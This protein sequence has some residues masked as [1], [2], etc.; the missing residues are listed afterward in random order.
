[1]VSAASEVINI[2]ADGSIVPST[3]PIQRNGDLY[4]L[5]ADIISKFRANG[6]IVERDNITLDGAGHKIE[7]EGCFHSWEPEPPSYTVGIDLTKDTNVTIVNTEIRLFYDCIVL[8][9]SSYNKISGN[10]ITTNEYNGHGIDVRKYCDSNSISRNNIA[11]TSYGI[12]L[13]SSGNNTISENNITAPD[14]YGILLQNSSYNRISRNNITRSECGIALHSSH[15]NILRDNTIGLYQDSLEV[16]G[17]NFSDFINDVD[18]S[19]TFGGKPIYYWI[20]EHDR[21]VPLDAAYVC[22][23]NCSGITVENFTFTGCGHNILLAYTT[24]SLITQNSITGTDHSFIKL[25][26]SSNNSI[27]RNNIVN[28]EQGIILGQSS[29]NSISENNIVNNYQGIVLAYSSRNSISQNN[30]SANNNAGIW[31]GISFEQSS[32]NS[33]SQNN[34]TG[35]TG[36]GIALSSSSGNRFY[37]NSI[38]NNNPQVTCNNSTNTWDDGLIGNYWSDYDGTGSTPY[39]IDANNQDHHPFITL[40]GEQKEPTSLVPAITITAV[41]GVAGGA[42]LVYLSKVK[43]RTQKEMNTEKKE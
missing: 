30:I 14:N 33:I 2:A 5:T 24:N 4:T 31:Q 9:G 3:A 17:S 1:M 23:V 37:H 41:V 25:T 43:K 10:N 28:N 15:G 35:N 6:I 40:Y 7:S 19:N 27:I 21:K 29:Y 34:I 18:A 39:I 22:L 8:D 42:L 20:N 13:D 11:S 38:I 12:S 16:C 26:S 36:Y 32:D